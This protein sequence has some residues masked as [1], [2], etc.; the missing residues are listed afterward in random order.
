M[1]LT[2][3]LYKANVQEFSQCLKPQSES[4]KYKNITSEAS[5]ANDEN[6]RIYTVEK[7]A[8]LPGWAVFV[9]GFTERRD[10]E[11]MQSQSASAVIFLRI[12]AID[13]SRIFVVSY[14]TA[15]S[16]IDTPLI[17]PNFG[18]KVTLNSIGHNK[19]KNIDYKNISAR[20]TSRRENSKRAAS[21][22]SLAFEHD[23]EVLKSISG[24][25]VDP[26]LE[27]TV[28]GGAS[29]KITIKKLQMKTALAT[30]AIGWKQ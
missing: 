3:Y 8:Q 7:E 20:S 2:L 30:I 1:K 11:V 5:K 9:S 19:I 23:S 6:I 14:D 18:M 26:K 29:L 12:E 17:K 10:L 21:I 24:T 13:G 15:F 28:S 27:F 16:L 25:T 22:A 4:R